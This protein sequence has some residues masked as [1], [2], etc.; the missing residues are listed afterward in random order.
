MERF[1][2]IHGHF[3]QPPRENPWLESVELQDSAAPF[4]DWNERITAECYGRNTAARIFDGDGRIDAIVNN[5]SRISFNFGPTLLAW[6]KEK[7]PWVHDAIIEADRQ[8]QERFSGHGSA[9]AQNYNHMILPLANERDRETQVLWGIR[10]FEHR[11]GRMP[12]GMWLAE[13]AADSPTLE[14]LARHGIQFTI[15]SPFQ[16]RHIRKIGDEE[17]H[18]ANGARLDPTRPYLMTLPSGKSI[19]LF[20]YDAPVSQAVAFEKLLD[21]GEK[22]AHRI[23]GAFSDERDWDQLVHIA[24]DGE[25]YGHH[26]RWGEMALAYALR[27]IEQQ[28]LAKLTNYGE[29]LEKHPPEWE[30]E[31]HEGSAWSC[32]HGIGRWKENCGCNSGG[33]GG[34][35]QNWRSPLRNALDWLRDEV[36]PVY[37]AKAKALLKNPW[38]ARDDYISV[39][40]NRDGQVDVFLAKHAARELSEDD[41]VA[42]L[43]MMEL[44][45]HAM[46]MYTSC[47]WF[48]DELSGIETVQVIQYAGRVIQLA[49]DV[50]GKDYESGFL[51]LLEHAKSNIPENCDGRCIYNKFVKP[52]MIS[53]ENVVAHH[54]ISSLFTAYDQERTRVFLYSFEEQHRKLLTAGKARLAVG[55]TRVW[56]E[57][58]RESRLY[59]YAALYLGEHHVTAAVKPF[60]DEPGYAEIGKELRDSFDR[61][62]FPETIRAMDRHFGTQSY[63][64][65]SLFKDEQRRILDEILSSTRQDLEN[66][67]RLIV[68]RYT[69][70]MRFLEDLGTPLPL[71]LKTAAD[72]ILHIDI[73]RQFEIDQTD[74][75]RLTALLDEAK[76]HRVPVW[77]DELS[78]A[79]TRKMEGII[80]KM[81]EEPGDP[82][83]ARHAQQLAAIIREMPMDPNLWR[84]R[85]KYW[86][87]LRTVLPEFRTKA[88]QDESAAE[89]VKHFLA[90][91]EQLNV[92]PRHLH[93]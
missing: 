21:S 81:Q 46:L 1:V 43:K 51:K 88:Q 65:R 84:V 75:E 70:L 22:F 64:L 14:V 2:C 85:N 26:H 39:I 13:T 47:G 35:H 42:V 80:A 91:G 31:I 59:I 52:A 12:E 66:R 92:A 7:M 89:Y 76:K 5:Y 58:T 63:S 71:P 78:F 48:F 28:K 90:L 56:F 20:F 15:L 74:I 79:I 18:D 11:F 23:V 68:E 61:A 41:K 53:W 19:T 4:H 67:N 54:A 10:D 34:W 50:L 69:P 17:W 87:M 6:M 93:P 38:A 36:A 49:R 3:Y 72:F 33:H 45:R 16:A 8:S 82:A 9:I 25:S 55:T 37:Q 83:L 60:N 32:S 77:D 24:T 44:Q 27:F 62:D 40:L 57:I 73:V 29:Y 86:R 30:A